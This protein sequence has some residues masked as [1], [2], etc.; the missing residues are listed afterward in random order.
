VGLREETNSDARESGECDHVEC[1]HACGVTA[2]RV[3]SSQIKMEKICCQYSLREREQFPT[4][5]VAVGDDYAAAAANTD[6]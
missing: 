1:V 2:F 4:R 5:D 6:E 3:C